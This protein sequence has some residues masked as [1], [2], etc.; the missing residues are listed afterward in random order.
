MKKPIAFII[1]FV[2]FHKQQLNA[3][4]LALIVGITKYPVSSGWSELDTDRDVD[5]ISN[6]LVKKG[7]KSENI[8]ILRNQEATLAG[9]RLALNNLLLNTQYGDVIYF[10]FSG[11][12]H[13][14]EDDGD[15]ELDGLDEVLVPFD[16][17]FPISTP[18]QFN[19]YLRDDELGVYFDKIAQKAGHK[20]DVLI[21]LDACYSGT[22]IRGFGKARG[23]QKPSILLSTKKQ[24]SHYNEKK[25]F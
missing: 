4:K 14:I 9:L 23:G 19:F 10:H 16:A 20:G 12:G 22:G 6:A 15:D 17:I 24:G 13:S 5:L 21:T 25:N 3:E 18:S 11:H 8:S 1:L 7:F 2:L